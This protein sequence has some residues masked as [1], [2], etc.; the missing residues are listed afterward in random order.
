MIGKV[1]ISLPVRLLMVLSLLVGMLAAAVP[2]MAAPPQGPDE[3][4]LQKVL[5]EFEPYAEKARQDWQVPGMAIAVVQGDKTVYAKGFGVKTVGGSDPVDKDTIFQMGSTTK[6]FTSALMGMQVDAKKVS[7]QDKVVDH[8]PDFQMYD[9]W[10]AKEFTVTDSMAQRSGLVGYAGDAQSFLGFDRAHLIRSLRY[11]KPVSSFRSQFA[12]QNGFW[13]VAGSIIEKV[14]GQ[15]WEDNVKKR[16]LEPLGMTS[17]TVDTVGFLAAPNVATMHATRDG[18]VVSL[19]TDRGY[20]DWLDVYGPAGSLNSNVVDYAKWVR[21]H[22]GDGTFEGKQL[23]S[24]ES[25]DYIHAPKT[26]VGPTTFAEQ[27][28]Y[29][30]GWMYSE[31]YPYPMLWHTGGT[32]GFTTN[33]VFVPK[34]KMGFII[35][36]NLEGST[37]PMILAQ[38]FYDMYFGN[39]ARDWSGEL[40]AKTQQA[41]AA[42]KPVERPASPAPPRSLDVYTGTYHSEV[43]GDLVLSV[44]GDKLAGTIG[45]VQAPLVLEPWDGDTFSLASGGLLGGDASQVT[46]VMDGNTVQGLRLAAFENEGTDLFA[47]A[48]P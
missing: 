23:V 27:N 36:T 4:Q 42:G 19:G 14:T 40:L 22:L 9:P 11:M 39:P 43:Y 5:A 46:F 6:A 26:I 29:C 38:K 31:L 10:V 45:P 32:A 21:L 28:Y 44:D 34:A 2:A 35:V 20:L 41:K 13:L 1:S 8:L 17:T 25:M 33:V 16:I 48:N 47:R 18:K 37:L 12:Y 15:S 3:A 24:K 7:W 30:Q